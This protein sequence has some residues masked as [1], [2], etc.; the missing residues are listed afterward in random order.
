[1]HF[2]TSTAKGTIKRLFPPQTEAVI[3][4]IADYTSELSPEEFKIIEATSN[5]RQQEFSTGRM[6][7]KIA[8]A[9]IDVHDISILTG[10]NREPIWPDSIIGSISHCRDLAGAVVSSSPQISSIGFDVENIKPLKND[11]SRIICTEKEK[12]LIKEQ[13]DYP[14]ETI[15]LLHFSIKEA[16]FK[17]IYAESHIRI[18][19]KDQQLFRDSSTKQI[20]VK[21]DPT[22]TNAKVNLHYE[23]TSTHIFTCAWINK[24]D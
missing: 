4:P 17:C 5:K 11:I 15:V 10:D 22:K 3:L 23:I 7:A 8:L 21:L 18:G 13:N 6:C 12:N 14:Y 16:V 20:E 19:F 9:A 1:V 24:A 2:L